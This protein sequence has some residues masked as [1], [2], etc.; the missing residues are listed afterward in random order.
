MT[1]LLIFSLADTAVLITKVSVHKCK[2]F[3]PD[4]MEKEAVFLE[5]G[6]RKKTS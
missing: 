6:N 2:N 4:I 5:K 3:L 1:V